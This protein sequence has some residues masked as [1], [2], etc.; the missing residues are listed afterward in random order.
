MTGD[1]SVIRKVTKSMSGSV[2]S[3]TIDLF[4]GTYGISYGG[5]PFDNAGALAI[6]AVIG[7]PF[8]I[9]LFPFYLY[10]FL[11]LMNFLFP[12]TTVTVTPT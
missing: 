5:S 8:G 4:A 11:H 10:L 1:S 3:Y 9:A 2:T 12:S 7:K 6:S